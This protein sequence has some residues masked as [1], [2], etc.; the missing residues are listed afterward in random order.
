MLIFFSSDSCDQNLRAT[1]NLQGGGSRTAD[2]SVASVES[3]AGFGQGN[4]VVDR[5][6]F[7]QVSEMHWPLCRIGNI[8]TAQIGVQDGLTSN[9]LLRWR[10]LLITKWFPT[11]IV[12]L[13]TLA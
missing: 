1:E 7:F 5:D 2:A 4:C 6:G 8:E 12:K 9:V 13:A 3:D 11:G 10:M